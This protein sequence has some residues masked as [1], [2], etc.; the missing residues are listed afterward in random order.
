MNPQSLW[1]LALICVIFSWTC[2]FLR[3]SRLAYRWSQWGSC[4]DMEFF[5]SKLFV[6]SVVY[7]VIH[8]N[9]VF[10]TWTGRYCL[11]RYHIC[12]RPVLEKRRWVW[13]TFVLRYYGCYCDLTLSSVWAVSWDIK[14][15]YTFFGM[16]FAGLGSL[17]FCF[18]SICLSSCTTWMLQLSDASWKSHFLN[19]IF[20]LRETFIFSLI[21]NFLKCC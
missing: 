18:L 11:I 14:C 13:W 7:I 9:G 16:Y 15:I 19:V 21:L 2:L 20:Y 8:W 6:F 5:Q 1:K 10:I 17:S 12:E 4:P 3:K